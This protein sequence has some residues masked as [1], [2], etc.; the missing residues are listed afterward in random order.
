M[1]NTYNWKNVTQNIRLSDC[2]INIR[3]NNFIRMLPQIDMAP[4][5]IK[6]LYKLHQNYK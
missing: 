2:S 3:D 1:L 5:D 4:D 6:Q